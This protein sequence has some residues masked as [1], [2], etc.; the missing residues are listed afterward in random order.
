MEVI[1]SGDEHTAIAVIVGRVDTIAANDFEKKMEK[2]ISSGV[3]KII[4][5]MEKMAYIS[6]AG[7]RSVLI[8]C[9]KAQ[10]SDVVLVWCCMNSIVRKIFDVSGF[11]KLVNLV[12]SLDEARE[13]DFDGKTI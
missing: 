9:K 8:L 5:D 1:L 13:R 4:I 10:A 7:L 11:S 6:S 2:T 3:K 12:G